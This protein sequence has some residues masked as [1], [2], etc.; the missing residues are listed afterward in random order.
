MTTASAFTDCK[1]NCQSVRK[2]IDLKQTIKISV[3]KPSKRVTD[4][5][6]HANRSK[7]NALKRARDAESQLADANLVAKK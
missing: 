2:N 1:N 3:S 6:V 5:M 7:L 4:R